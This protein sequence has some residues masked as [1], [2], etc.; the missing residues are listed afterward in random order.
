MKGFFGLPQND[1]RLELSQESIFTGLMKYNF[2]IQI[3]L[4]SND[5]KKKYRIATHPVE[6]QHCHVSTK[7]S[8]DTKT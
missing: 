2:G 6:T 1:K 3:S 8:A 4:R 7:N 5:V